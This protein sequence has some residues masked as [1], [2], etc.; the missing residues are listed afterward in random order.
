[1]SLPEDNPGTE[2]GGPQRARIDLSRRSVLQGGAAVAAGL[3]APAVAFHALLAKPAQARRRR[4]SPDYGE[5]FETFDPN[6]GLPLLKLPRGFQY[7]SF[8]IAFEPMSDGTPTP[9]RHDGMCVVREIG[10]QRVV[11]IRNHEL[12]GGTP[13]GP[14]GTPTFTDDSAGGTTNLIFDRHR[15]KLLEDWASLSGTYRNCAGGC[16]PLGRSWIS[17]EETTTAGHGYIF[18]VP[19]FGRASA[20]PIREAGRFAHEAVAVEL[21]S[22]HLYMTEDADVA[23]FYRFIPRRRWDLER[24]GRLQMLRVKDSEGPVN[25]N[26]GNADRNATALARGLPQGRSLEL[27]E[28]FEVEWIDI[29]LPDPGEADPTVAEQGLA[30]GGAFFTRGEGAWYS[31]GSV[32]FTSTDGGLAQRGQVWE[33]DI[34]AQ[35]L[36]LIFESPD[37]FTLNK[38]DNITVAPGGG[39]LLCEDGGGVRDAEDDFVRGEQLVGLSTD[40]ELFPFA[41]NNI[42]IPDG[43]PIGGETGDQRGKEWAGATFTRDGEWLFVNNHK[44]GI[45]FAITGPWEQGPLGRRRSGKFIDDDDDD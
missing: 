37:A 31:R 8:G 10:R 40:G 30:L 33:L 3:S 17:C 23:G 44:P 43:L 41:E 21:R 24:G 11:L 38:P 15:A 14:A 39:L 19:A 36:T 32:F 25:L 13:F 4:V 16:N 34:R 28:S 35:R 2:A 5:L 22:G 27:G 9:R 29:P 45:T 26:G 1:M 12:S 20:A 6:T 18:E 7:V 42:I